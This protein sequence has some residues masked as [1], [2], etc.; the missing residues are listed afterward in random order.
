MS[1]RLSKL[2]VGPSNAITYANPQR[3]FVR[4]HDS[5]TDDGWEKRTA[6]SIAQDC[7]AESVGWLIAD[8]DNT[9]LLA[10]DRDA[11]KNSNRTIRIPTICIVEIRELKVGKSI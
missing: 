11:C 4:W 5:E 8:N 3:V 10:G 7:I 2:L 1:R 9:I 6:E